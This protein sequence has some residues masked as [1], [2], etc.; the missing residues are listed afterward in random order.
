ME[1]KTSWSYLPVHYHT[2]I[3]MI[4]NVTQRTVFWN[5]L[6][7]ER[8][9]IRFSN[10]YGKEPLRFEKVI[11]GQQRAGKE[12]IFAMAPITCGGETRIEIAP[13][14]E[15]ESDAIDWNIEA[16]TRI[17]V[18]VYFKE[19]NNIECACSTWSARSC[20]TVY[21]VGGDYTQA[22]KFDEKQ[23]RELYPYVEADENKADIVAGITAIR[24]FSQE[25][26]KTVALFGDSITHM[27]YYAD[28][29]MQSVYER[30]PG[31]VAVLNRGI[32]GNR[33][34]HDATYV[35]D[36]PGNGKCF[37]AAAV[38]RF[39]GDVYGNEKP[40]YV[41]MLEGVNDMMHP[42]VFG[43]PEERVTA[44]DLAEGT[45]QIIDCAHKNGSRIYIGTVMPFKC[46]GMPDCPWAQ[47]VRS[48]FNAW[49]KIQQC[50]DGVID[51]A[52]AVAREPESAYM[53][54]GLHIG[55]GLHPNAAGGAAMA[56][57][58]LK[59]VGRDAG[60]DE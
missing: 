59:V 39:S 48:E 6:R 7:G 1:W 2:S 33:I 45:R 35:P 3:G 4:E 17:V 8:I 46:D 26:V 11:V 51:F 56:E 54:D 36:M 19:K 22:Q 42:E 16:G 10:R 15:F 21:G 32:G 20:H 28:A 43:Y 27:S 52:A 18:S 30:Y 23:S 53:K 47:N 38:S 31:K 58:A 57:A 41:L 5:N 60:F 49:V 29:L 55:D 12:D 25:R 44:A 14:A 24:L 34:L 37:G 9:R 40:E 50:A 13:G